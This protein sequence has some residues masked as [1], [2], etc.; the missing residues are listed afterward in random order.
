MRLVRR[1]TRRLE[2]SAQV[3]RKFQICEFETP[4]E[5]ISMLVYPDSFKYGERK[6]RFSFL[7]SFFIQSF[8]CEHDAKR[9]LEIP[10]MNQI[11]LELCPERCTNYESFRAL[12]FWR[13]MLSFILRGLERF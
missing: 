2:D 11:R 10:I 7:I 13:H 6:K 1:T 12:N 9:A 5:K 8:R 3:K 4:Y